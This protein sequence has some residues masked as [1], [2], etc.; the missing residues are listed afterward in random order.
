MKY[1]C[2]VVMACTKKVH[3][4]FLC[5]FTALYGYF[6]NLSIHEDYQN[7][8]ESFLDI[9]AGH[10]WPPNES[11]R[12]FPHRVGVSAPKVGVEEAL[13]FSPGAF[14]SPRRRFD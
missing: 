9:V 8:S 4:K 14:R 12:M 13:T 10:H 2:N 7:N 3:K 6:S 11:N 1:P 5:A